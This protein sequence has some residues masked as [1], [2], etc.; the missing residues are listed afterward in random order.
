M[1]DSI[2]FYM[3]YNCGMKVKNIVFD[4]NGVLVNRPVLK[5]IV[6]LKAMPWDFYR[7][8]KLFSS[9][10]WDDYNRG[11][12]SNDE[13]VF[14]AMGFTDTKPLHDFMK[15]FYS[16][17]LEEDRQ[18]AEFIKKIRKT[19]RVYI[20]TNQA[21]EEWKIIKQCDIV[22][23]TDGIM[24]SCEAGYTKPEKE[25]YQLLLD[26]FDLKPQET[27]FVDDRERNVEVAKEL[28]FHGV[29][30]RKSPETIKEIEALLNR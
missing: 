13:E 17:E 15:R 2:G 9:P 19:H 16:M 6:R 20:L 3:L 26:K 25:I 30:H 21:V 14:R 8:I 7:L 5:N 12:Y 28:G 24:V 29:R 11:K 10:Q 18:L 4:I 22:K 27:V 1:V 23:N